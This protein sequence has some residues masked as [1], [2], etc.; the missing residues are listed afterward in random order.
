MGQKECIGAAIGI[1]LFGDVYLNKTKFMTAIARS[2][3]LKLLSLPVI[4]RLEVIEKLVSSIKKESEPSSKLRKRPDLDKHFGALKG[5]FGD[6][7]A[8]QKRMRDEW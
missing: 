8:Y 5:V 6:G 7:L 1:S 3:L 2:A 4:D